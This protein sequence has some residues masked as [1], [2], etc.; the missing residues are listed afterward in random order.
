MAAGRR[1][2]ATKRQEACRRTSITC[3]PLGAQHCT[4][5]VLANKVNQSTQLTHVLSN[6]RNWSVTLRMPDD[7]RAYNIAHVC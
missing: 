1:L 3:G 2:A 7:F 5:V 4:S 6:A